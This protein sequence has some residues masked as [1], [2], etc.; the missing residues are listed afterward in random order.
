MPQRIVT[1][2]GL[3]TEYSAMFNEVPP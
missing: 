3:R 1:V 2:I